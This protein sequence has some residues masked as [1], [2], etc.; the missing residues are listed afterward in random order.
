[1]CENVTKIL[2]YFVKNLKD[3]CYIDL[4]ENDN[5]W[6]TLKLSNFVE[7]QRSKLE[8]E[9]QIVNEQWRKYVENILKENKGLD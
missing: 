1:M 7:N 4:N 2:K 5:S 9:K 6:S 3:T 8:A